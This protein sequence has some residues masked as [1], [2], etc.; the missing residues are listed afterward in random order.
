MQNNGLFSI[1]QSKA[2]YIARVQIPIEFQL[3]VGTLNLFA[4]EYH[5]TLDLISGLLCRLQLNV[6]VNTY[7][8]LFLNTAV[9]CASL[10]RTRN[11]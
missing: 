10:D 1:R 2:P 5:L 6:R 3:C 8:A 7:A 11:C 9:S 4:S